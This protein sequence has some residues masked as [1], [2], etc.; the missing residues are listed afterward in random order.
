MNI[1]TCKVNKRREWNFDPQGGLFSLTALSIVY[2]RQD[3]CKSEK[4][5]VDQRLETYAASHVTSHDNTRTE[6]QVLFA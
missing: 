2:K 5:L 3:F 4:R 1:M 6:M